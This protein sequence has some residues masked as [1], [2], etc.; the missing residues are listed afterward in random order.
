MKTKRRKILQPGSIYVFSYKK[1]KQ[2]SRRSKRHVCA[3]AKE[4]NGR[5]INPNVDPNRAGTVLGTGFFINIKWYKCIGM[6]VK[7]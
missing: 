3:W 7:P 5:L 2:E 1:Y 6:K 4:I